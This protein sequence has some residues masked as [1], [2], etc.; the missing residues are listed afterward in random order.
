MIILARN[1]VFGGGPV[2]ATNLSSNRNSNNHKKVKMMTLEESQ[3][4][5]VVACVVLH[6]NLLSWL[7]A[8]KEYK[9]TEI[10]A[11]KVRLKVR[12]IDLHSSKPYKEVQ[13]KGEDLDFDVFGGFYMNIIRKNPFCMKQDD[14][15]PIK[16]EEGDAIIICADSRETDQ[17]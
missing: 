2:Y 8:D 7:V 12:Q 4:N 6:K 15:T 13:L 5:F 10:C 17:R 16:G 3:E 14:Q 1:I 9:S 11:N